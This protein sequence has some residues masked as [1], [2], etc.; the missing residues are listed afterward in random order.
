MDRAS[1]RRWLSLAALGLS[2]SLSTSL[3]AQTDQERAGARAAAKDGIAAFNE[4]NF[5]KSLSLLERAE[6]LVH[7]PTHLL[8]IARAQVKLGLLVEARESYKDIINENLSPTAPKA[9]LNA[10]NIAP[11]ELAEIEGRIA[12]LTLELSSSTGELPAD[13]EV[14][15]DGV[16]LSSNLYG[17][18]VPTNPGE[19]RVTVT[20]PGMLSLEKSVVLEEGG[21]GSLELVLEVDPNAPPPVVVGQEEHPEPAAAPEGSAPQQASTMSSRA[22]WGWV[23]AGTGTAFVATGA[24]LGIASLSGVKKAENDDSLCG[25]DNVCTPEGTKKVNSAQTMA[26]LADIGIGVGLV[27]IGVG[28]YLLF[29]DDEESTEV[30]VHRVIPS[31]DSNG[32]YLTIQGAF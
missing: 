23:A 28:A 20:A 12:K 29:T 4:G 14:Q 26:L 13:V 21:S 2:L 6:K 22:K 3:S 1:S 15:V 7:A 8:F 11:Q 17:L 18:A 9:F 31:A 25:S 16:P 30:G 27:G 10:Q 32:G 19:R 24:A 5:E